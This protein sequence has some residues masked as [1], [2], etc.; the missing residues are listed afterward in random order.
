M[1]WRDA[2]RSCGCRQVRFVVLDSGQQRC[3]VYAHLPPGL[4]RVRQGDRVRRGDVIAR[5]D[6]LG[7]LLSPPAFPHCGWTGPVQLA[8]GVR[9]GFD[10]FTHDESR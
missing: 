3:A 6:R 7:R 1:V 4:L 5:P 8:E 10:E 2:K 9:F